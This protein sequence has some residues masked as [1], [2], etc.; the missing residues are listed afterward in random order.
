MAVSVR[1]DP[2][3]EAKLTQ[4]ANLLG[5]TKSDFIKDAIERVL[6]MKNR[7]CSWRRCAVVENSGD[8][9]PRQRCPA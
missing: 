5:I 9:M 4:Q 1:L 3:I 6:G 2:V 8:P 7:P